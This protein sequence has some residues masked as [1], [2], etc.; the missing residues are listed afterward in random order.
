MEPLH[1]RDIRAVIDGGEI[2]RTLGADERDAL[3]A[4]ASA[5]RY[6]DGE[7]M[8]RED[9][10]GLEL[11]LI[12]SGRARVSML[13][14]DGDLELAELGPGALVGE[15]AVLMGQRRTSTVT[16]VGEVAAVSFAAHAVREVAASS[17]AFEAALRKLVEDR[18]FHT[19][20][21]IP[22]SR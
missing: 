14:A 1:D 20:S 18:A 11:L 7:A 9:E 5:V 3:E 15:V 19:I 10:E 2:F 13:A 6:A 8:I 17:P 16:A 12:V 22:S 21:M 4:A